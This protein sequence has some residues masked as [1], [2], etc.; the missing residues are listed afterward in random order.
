[1]NRRT[2]LGTLTGA[3]LAAPLLVSAQ[4][5]PS[6]RRVGYIYSATPLVDSW[7]Q[8][9]DAGLRE[10][11]WAEH[12]NIVV[13][14]RRAG[15]RTEAALAAAVELARLKVGVVVVASTMTA[16]SARQLTTTIPVGLPVP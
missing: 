4:Q 2:F 6:V 15:L 14:R 10:H 12:Q 3:L 1:M 8:A 7:W 5:A 16:R 13:A 9:L 11:G